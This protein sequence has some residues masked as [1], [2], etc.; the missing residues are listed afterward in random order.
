MCV[1]IRVIQL[2]GLPKDH[3]RGWRVL[4]EKK[5]AALVWM[6]F[7]KILFI[8]FAAGDERVCSDPWDSE[9]GCLIMLLESRCVREVRQ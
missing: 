8:A 9:M 3:T 1:H 4:V 7:L 5:Q 2:E 6:L